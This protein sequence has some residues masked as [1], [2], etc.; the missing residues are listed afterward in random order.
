MLQEQLNEL[1]TQNFKDKAAEQREKINKLK[2]TDD[3]I[4]EASK[5][6]EEVKPEPAQAPP[7]VKAESVHS[8]TPA[9]S[10]TKSKK[11]AKPAWAT[12]EKAAE[13]EKEA[14]IDDLLEFAYELDYE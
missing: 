1:K 8:A 13:E 10:K 11:A 2:A 5:A 9:P 14:E 12:T 3:L 4:E 7:S 6:I